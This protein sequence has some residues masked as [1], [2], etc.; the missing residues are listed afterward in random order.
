MVVTNATTRKNNV[1]PKTDRDILEDL[2]TKT[3]AMEQKMTEIVGQSVETNS[4]DFFSFFRRFLYSCGIIYQ[5]SPRGEGG[6]FRR[7]FWT[8]VR[9]FDFNSKSK[10]L[11][12]KLK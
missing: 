10:S 2:L 4:R 3:T 7:I 1:K 5:K 8:F 11:T 12:L 6:G 9:F